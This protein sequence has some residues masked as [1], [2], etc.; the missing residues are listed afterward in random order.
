M[1]PYYDDGTCTIYHGD[2][3]EI[4]PRL[5]ADVVLT[6]TPYG[7]GLDYGTTFSD[8]PA[9]LDRLVATALPQMRMAAPVVALTTGV[10][11]M[12]RFPVPTW[13][14]SWFQVNAFTSTGYWGFNMWQPVLCYGTDPYLRRGRG[15]H[16]DVIQTTATLGSNGGH[17][18]PPSGHPCP[19]P[20]PSWRKIMLR[21]SPDTSDVVLDPFMGSGTTLRAAK[22]LGRTAIG[23]EIEERYC[24]IAANRLAQEVLALG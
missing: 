19:K 14:L 23:I 10:V 5:T 17:D 8:T 18:N 12:W 11:N 21:V 13:V 15:R 22:D 4:L 16:Q 6:D 24:E 7:I 20:L 9:Y 1:I 2:C 3:M